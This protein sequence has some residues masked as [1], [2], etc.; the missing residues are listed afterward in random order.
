MNQFDRRAFLKCGAAFAAG[1]AAA[2]IA[3]IP[4]V[5]TH[6]HLF[7][8]GRPEGVPWPPKD[9]AILYKPAL[10]DRYRRVT[11][12][13]GV[14]G[15]IEIEC[16]PWP[17][18]NDW[19]LNTAAKDAIIVGTIGDL[20]PDSVEFRQRLDR[21]HKNPLWLGIRYGNLWDR[22]LTKS[23]AKPKFIDGLKALADA[24]LA[25]DTAN[26]NLDL[27][28]STVRLTDTVPRLRV[29]IDHLP[30]FDVPNT[31]GAKETYEHTL[32]ELASRPQVY[33]KLSEVLRRVDGR[34]PLDL[35]FYRSRLDELLQ[36]FGD[37]RLLFGSDWP[38]S[39]LWAQY[40][41]V[42]GLTRAYALSK[43]ND[44]AA[45]LLWKNS[46][47]AYRWRPRNADQQRLQG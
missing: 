26:Q 16:S 38:N 3:P 19:V 42:L 9:N 30:Q 20:E 36:R 22:D 8:P 1:Q 41:D 11:E 21:F 32:A 15:A 24:G 27:L 31:P 47:A 46:M 34:V 2:A 14:V 37:N 12:K 6:I 5:D 25:L 40:P 7:D 10:P 23:L 44:V 17:Q 29:I 13:I 35:G 43:G 39:D 28:A 33:V 18:D 4:V 45:K